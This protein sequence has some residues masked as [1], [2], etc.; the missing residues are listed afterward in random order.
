MTVPVRIGCEG[1]DIV[2]VVD[3]SLLVSVNQCPPLETPN[4]ILPFLGFMTVNGD[5]VTTSLS[6]DG[7]VTPVDA[8]LEAPISGDLY[9]TALNILIAD[10]GTVSLNGFGGIMAGLPVGINMFFVNSRGEVQISQALKTN[11]DFIRLGTLTQGTGGK[12]DA[13]LLAKTDP[14]NDDGYNPVVD[15]SLF[16][17]GG[18]RLRQGSRDKLGMRINDDLTGVTTFNIEILGY[19]RF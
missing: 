4:C 11:F 7:S 16:S 13:F 15:M 8:F 3:E 9:I 1:T 5:G 2:R 17:P 10:G 18:L 19:I 12:T 6:V 14:A